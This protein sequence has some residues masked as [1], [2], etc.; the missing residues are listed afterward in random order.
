MD[1]ASITG[2]VV[3]HDGEGIAG[4]RVRAY[5]PDGALVPRWDETDAGG[6]F[7]V[8]GL[9]TGSYRLVISA[10]TCEIGGN[11]L[12]Y[13]AG[14]PSRLTADASLADPLAV[15]VGSPTAVSGDLVAPVASRP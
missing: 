8:G 7:D 3:D 2:R 4:C 9:T 13:K 5:T 12:Y 6:L 14:D 11:D 15:V 10:G 1:G